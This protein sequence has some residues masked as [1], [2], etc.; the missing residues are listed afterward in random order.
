MIDVQKRAGRPKEID[1]E[2]RAML[3]LFARRMKADQREMLKN[4]W[5]T[6]RKRQYCR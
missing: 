4:Y 5:V 6:K 1:L 3:F 2:K